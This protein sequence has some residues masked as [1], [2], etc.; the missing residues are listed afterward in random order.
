MDDPKLEQAT[1]LALPDVG[2]D[3]TL[4]LLW[5]E[6]VQVEFSIDRKSERQGA[7]RLFTDK[8]AE[9][10]GY[11]RASTPK[12]RRPGRAM[13][14]RVR[15]ANR[16]TKL[17]AKYADVLSTKGVRP[18]GVARLFVHGAITGV[19]KALAANQ[20]ARAE[21]SP[22]DALLFSPQLADEPGMNKIHARAQGLN[23]LPLTVES[24]TMG[25]N[26]HRR[27]RTIGA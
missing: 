17:T 19:A 20:Q 27:G 8:I 1:L 14:G 24:E 10:S 11:L 26:R 22:V 16:L 18:T 5:V 6:V 7:V 4:H 13:N 15:A 21:Q 12:P 23:L 2:Q 3:E 25:A 9:P